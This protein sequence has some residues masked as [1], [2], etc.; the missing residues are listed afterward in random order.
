MKECNKHLSTVVTYDPAATAMECPLCNAERRVM[1]F[2]ECEPISKADVLRVLESLR[3]VARLQG[4]D[5]LIVWL[6]LVFICR[7]DFRFRI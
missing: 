4:P 1:P 3:D 2:V 6:Q 7:F 5:W